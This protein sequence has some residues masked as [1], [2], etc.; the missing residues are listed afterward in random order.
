VLGLVPHAQD[1]RCLLDAAL[2]PDTCVL[3][4][5]FGHTVGAWRTAGGASRHRRRLKK[6]RGRG[7]TPAPGGKDSVVLSGHVPVGEA[8]LRAGYCSYAVRKDAQGMG[9]PH[10]MAADSSGSTFPCQ[11]ASVSQQL[12]PAPVRVPRDLPAPC[13]SCQRPCARRHAPAFVTLQHRGSP[14]AGR[15]CAMLRACARKLAR[16]WHGK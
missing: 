1:R 5:V 14:A 10:A 9:G 3:V 6:A 8:M 16:L 13:L 7:A 4:L 15:P 2:S 12:A 11:H